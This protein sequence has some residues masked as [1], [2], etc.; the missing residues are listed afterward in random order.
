MEA[1]ATARRGKEFCLPN[2]WYGGHLERRRRFR[3]YR[4]RLRRR[5]RLQVDRL[6]LA[7]CWNTAGPFGYLA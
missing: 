1:F 2:A 3:L 4:S 6:F 7:F 5:G